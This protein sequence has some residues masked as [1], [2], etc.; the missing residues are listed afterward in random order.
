MISLDKAAQLCHLSPGYFSRTFS[1][2]F[3][4]NYTAYTNKLKIKW[5]KELLTNTDFPVTQISDQLGFND[6]GYFI[7]VFKKQEYLTPGLYRKYVSVPSNTS[8]E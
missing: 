4:T 2:E 6:P 1:K 5:A 7:K 3:N 8:S